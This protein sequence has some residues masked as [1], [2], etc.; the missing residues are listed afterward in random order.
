MREF[1]KTT[2]TSTQQGSIVDD[3]MDMTVCCF[4][5]DKMEMRYAIANQTVFIIRNGENIKLKGDNMP[6]GRY[7]REKAHFQTFNIKIEK[8]DMV[9]M[10]SDGIQDQLGGESF[11]DGSQKKFL[12]RNLVNTL[13]ELA[14]K[15]VDGQCE[16]LEQTILR[17]RGNTPQV[18][19]MTL[20]GIRV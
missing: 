12:L 10:F 9:Y 5:F 17:W 16:I 7:I 3:G 15:P 20:V 11:K 18:D 4:D 2:L 6:V 19:D 13:T 8:D 14:G 1:V